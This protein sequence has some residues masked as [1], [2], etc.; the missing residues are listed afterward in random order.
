MQFN[1]PW[2]VNKPLMIKVLYAVQRSVDSEK[3]PHDQS[4][5]CNTTVRGPDSKQGTV[6][7]HCQADWDRQNCE[8]PH[9][10]THVSSVK[11]D[12]KVLLDL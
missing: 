12:Y 9:T 8:H 5:V 11:P 2:T 3:I 10:R 1:G 4:A 7:G 6:L